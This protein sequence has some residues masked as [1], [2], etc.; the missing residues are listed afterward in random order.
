MTAAVRTGERTWLWP[1]AAAAGGALA[2]LAMSAPREWRVGMGLAVVAAGAAVAVAS[3]PIG[4]A[5]VLIITM[6]FPRGAFLGGARI[7]P[8][9]VAVLLVLGFWAAATLLR[10]RLRLART[11]AD[12]AWACMAFAAAISF[13]AGALRGGEVSP[14]VGIRELGQLLLFGGLYYWAA[15][16]L[17]APRNL[18][19]AVTIFLAVSCAEAVYA[20]AAQFAPS[21]AALSSVGSYVQRATGTADSGFGAYMAGALVVA[22]ALAGQVPRRSLPAML[23][24]VGVLVAGVVSSGTRGATLAAAVGVLL[25]LVASRRRW[26]MVL[27]LAAAVVMFV[28]LPRLAEA[29]R[30]AYRVGKPVT[31][32]TLQRIVGWRLGLAIAAR[33]PAWG[34]GPGANAAAFPV[35]SR[36]PGFVVERVEGAFSAY[37]QALME[38]GPLG[39]L[40]LLGFVVIVPGAAFR[41]YR[42]ARGSPS[43]AIGYACG[44]GM[45]TV[46]ATG[47]TGPLIQGGVGHLFF[48]L[49]GLTAAGARAAALQGHPE[50]GP[51]RIARG[52]EVERHGTA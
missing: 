41:A 48:L 22:V 44:C 27:T 8:P 30:I 24:A 40:G 6:Y 33:H 32:G 21:V 39:L 10:G 20:L 12:W 16:E 35:L 29:S 38:T 17:S 37:V 13:A 9:D 15:S 2:A 11:P 7:G 3:G 14:L 5:T 47:L 28:A 26:L 51:F 4:A 34:A 42:R 19:W 46:A 25:A 36:A 43:A 23:A 18:R 50:G 49:A 45:A 52:A 31:S 1:A